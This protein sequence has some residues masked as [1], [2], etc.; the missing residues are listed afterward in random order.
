MKRAHKIEK[1]VRRINQA[2]LSGRPEEMRPI[3]AEEIVMVFPGFGG[4]SQGA[5]A[6]VAGFRKFCDQAEVVS[7]E[8]GQLEIDAASNAAVAAFTFKM[9]YEVGGRRFESSGRDLWVFG[10]GSGEW[11]ATWRTMLDV[12]EHEVGDT[13]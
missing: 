8:E 7:F 13:A 2:W 1:L 4:R 9:V 6:M 11:Q 12:E 5:D 3:L 10:R